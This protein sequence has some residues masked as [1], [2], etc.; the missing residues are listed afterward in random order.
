M[1]PVARENRRATRINALTYWR[2]SLSGKML[3]ESVKLIC[4][5]ILCLTAF[6]RWNQ[7]SWCLRV[8]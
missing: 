2:F 8:G 7:G 6:Q 5:L 3:Q 4:V 1:Y